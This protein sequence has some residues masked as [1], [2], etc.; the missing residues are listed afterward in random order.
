M[1]ISFDSNPYNKYFKILKKG[2][3]SS[4][5]ALIYQKQSAK[6]QRYFKAVK[7]RNKSTPAIKKS[8]NS[9]VTKYKV[10]S[11]HVAVITGQ[12]E[13]A[14]QLLETIKVDPNAPDLHGWTPLH[15]A[16]VL[17]NA[18]M[19][20]L[21]LK[22]G[23]RDTFENDRY[24]TPVDLHE[25]IHADTKEIE[26]PILEITDDGEFEEISPRNFQDITGATYIDRMK[27]Q[28]QVL[29]DDWGLMSHEAP[30]YS[31]D[32]QVKNR[33]KYKVFR[34]EPPKIALQRNSRDENGNLIPIGSSTVA[35]RDI[36]PG[37]IICEYL[38]D[39][40]ESS[41]VKAGEEEY[42][43]ERIDGVRV[44]NLG[45]ISPDGYPNAIT[46]GLDN[47]S[48][49]PDR[50]F[51]IASETIKKGGPIV[52]DYSTHPVKYLGIEG[53]KGNPS[54]SYRYIEVRP[55]SL[56]N[57]LRNTDISAIIKAFNNSF[58]GKRKKV[59]DF[60]DYYRLNKIQYVMNTPLT[61]MKHVLAGNLTEKQIMPIVR[62]SLYTQTEF[63]SC[64]NSFQAE[65]IFRIMKQPERYTIV[66]NVL[67][68]LLNQGYTAVSQNV[69]MRLRMGPLEQYQDPNGYSPED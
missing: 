56:T 30:E 64:P 35:T 8:F 39:Y 40:C 68:N 65:I 61:F 62:T 41:E 26:E 63:F 7:N 24:G 44:R 46:Y 29:I 45:P 17:Q 9:H 15:H 42:R 5:S 52:W 34:H 1:H 33:R 66:R 48:G 22:Y 12:T 21:L 6:L 49:L 27:I 58:N 50:S 69:L 2:K 18:R 53:I 28:P 55:D 20:N 10:T 13:I 25:M 38:G 57:F 59:C 43:L 47:E 37:E 60:S 51:F 67:L 32:I 23:A 54:I 4:P 14:R 36:E 16:V 3:T 19:I 11:L 31:S